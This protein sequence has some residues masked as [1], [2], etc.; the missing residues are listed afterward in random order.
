MLEFEDENRE[1]I[2][3]R[4]GPQLECASEVLRIGRHAFDSLTRHFDEH[5]DD[6]DTHTGTVVVLVFTQ[7][8]R[9]C[10]ASVLVWQ[11]GY[12]A[13]SEVL[14]RSLF[15]THLAARFI[16][17][18]QLPQPHWSPHLH[19]EFKKL[20]GLSGQGISRFTDIN[21]RAMLYAAC[22]TLKLDHKTDRIK[23]LPGF[24][25]VLPA[26]FG[27][28]MSEAADEAETAIGKE[29][30]ERIRNTGTFH[31]FTGI[32]LLAEYCGADKSHYYQTLYGMQSGTTHGEGALLQL[33]NPSVDGLSQALCLPCAILGESL[34]DFDRVF[35]LGLA[36]QIQGLA[37]RIRSVFKTDEAS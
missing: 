6:F 1:I 30:A 26:G 13:E 15:D 36:E 17:E 16:I 12:A 19:G 29:W 20:C 25:G 23:A 27:E 37:Q 33:R 11:H 31:G 22:Q 8:L 35:S 3:D 34:E 5:K 9:R 21:F 2:A 14:T 18:P 24:W 28:K 32:R 10:R 7:L 4:F